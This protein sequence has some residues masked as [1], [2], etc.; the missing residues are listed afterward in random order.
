MSE[1]IKY[2]KAV[3]DR[4]TTEVGIPSLCSSNEYVIKAALEYAGELDKFVL[5][6]ATANQ[7]NQYGGY[8]GMKPVDFK[9]YVYA[10]ADN[11][12][13]ERKKIILGG[14]HLGPVAFKHLP[15]EDAMREAQNAHKGIC[16]RGF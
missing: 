6:E 1:G 10:L 15:E 16:K 3:I 14:D 13:C 11:I 12:G 8:T 7:V 4:K 5:I 2:I 9:N